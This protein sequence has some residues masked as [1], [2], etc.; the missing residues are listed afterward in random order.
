MLIFAGEDTPDTELAIVDSVFENLVNVQ[1]MLY[2]AKM[3][4]H[5]DVFTGVQ[6]NNGSFFIVYANMGPLASANITNT[7]VM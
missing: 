2:N 4:L 5:G 3:D 7:S 6:A 1:I